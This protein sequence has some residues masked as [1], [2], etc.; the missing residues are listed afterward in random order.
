MY[1]FNVEYEWYEK[2]AKFHYKIMK[3]SIQTVL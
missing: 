2:Y 3:I 1:M